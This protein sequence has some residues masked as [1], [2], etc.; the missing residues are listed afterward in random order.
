MDYPVAVLDQLAPHLR[1]LRKA[2]GLSQA[3]LAR[4]LG[5]TQ[6]R[7]A[8]IEHNPAVVSAG[9]L[10]GLLHMLDAELVVRDRQRTADT[11]S[12]LPSAGA[13]QGEW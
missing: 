3:E 5:V 11:T 6:S 2:R 1:S 12:S 7:I 10:I 9:Q 4:R 8:A 13:P